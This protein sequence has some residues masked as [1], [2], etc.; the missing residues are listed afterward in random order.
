MH[1]LFVA[2]NLPVPTNN[3]QAIRSLSIIQAL[4][5]SGH[6]LNF[7]SFAR[8]GRPEDLH[9]LSS[10]CRSIELLELEMT[11]LTQRADYVRRM[12]SLFVFRSFSIER[13]K[14]EAMRGK[15]QEQLQCGKYDLIV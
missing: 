10:L 12:G 4:E 3:G 15:I 2:T 5:S 7:V 13:F 14:S 6:E 9:P 1:I 8:R 11:N